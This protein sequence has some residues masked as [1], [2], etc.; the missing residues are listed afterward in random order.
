MHRHAAKEPVVRQSHGERPAADGPASRFSH[1]FNPLWGSLALQVAPAPVFVQRAPAAG[2]SGTTHVFLQDSLGGARWTV[3]YRK[4]SPPTEAGDQVVRFEDLA[5][6]LFKGLDS[7]VRIIG[8]AEGEW[9]R[10]DFETGWVLWAR[11]EN[12]AL[13]ALSDPRTKATIAEL[14]RHRRA[15]AGEG[16]TVS[17]ELASAPQAA[18]S[19]GRVF[20]WL[21]AHSAAIVNAERTYSVDRRAIAGAIAW[22]ALENP[23]QTFGGGLARFSGPGKVHVREHRFSEGDPVAAQVERRDESLPDLD[24]E[25]RSRVLATAE[26]AITYIGAIMNAFAAEGAAAGYFLHCDPPMLTT[27]FNAWDLTQAQSLFQQKKAPDPLSPNEFMGAW[28]RDHLSFVE[29]AVGQPD[30]GICEQSK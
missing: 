29:T 5:M 11:Q 20:L 27:F 24:T 3:T 26:G 21:V 4:E 1:G 14:M 18:T 28:V 17:I 6:Q 22:E 16:A 30:P 8:T 12:H 9:F 23:Y 2:S 25:Q 19:Q 7:V 13:H 10:L 15:S